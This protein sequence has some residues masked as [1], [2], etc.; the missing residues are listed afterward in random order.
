MFDRVFG[1]VASVVR[2]VGHAAGDAIRKV[3]HGARTAQA[4]LKTADAVFGGVPGEIVRNTPVLSNIAGFA[5]AG[6]KALS[7]F[8]K[9]VEAH[10]QNNPLLGEILRMQHVIKSLG[11]HTTQR[12]QLSTT[13]AA[14]DVRH[15]STISV[16]LPTSGFCDLHTLCMF[17]KGTTTTTAGFAAFPPFTSSLVK[18]LEVLVGG[19][20]VDNI[21]DYSH[22]FWTL[23]TTHGGANY[24]Q[25]QKPAGWADNAVTAPTA[26]T[27]DKPGCID[28]FIGFLSGNPRIV[29]MSLMPPMEVRLTLMDAGVLIPSAA[30]AGL[31]FTLKDIHWSIEVYRF[32]EDVIGQVLSSRL[33]QGGTI[34]YTWNTWT[35]TKQS[36]GT[37]N[38]YSMKASL[39]SMSASKLLAVQAPTATDT[40]N[41]VGNTMFSHTSDTLTSYQ[42]DVNGNY[43]TPA[44]S[45]G[46][47]EAWVNL[48]STF[49][50]QGNIGAPVGVDVTEAS[51][52]ADFFVMA[53]HLNMPSAG[54]GWQS[55]LDLR[56]TASV[57]T[58]RVSKTG[59]TDLVLYIF[60]ESESRMDIGAGRQAVVQL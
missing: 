50:D 53:A 3:G 12:V 34:P 11:Q 60:A 6:L 59:G 57:V 33:A 37:S 10:R 56:G 36:L 9:R 47:T 24:A 58:L 8:D 31:A 40:E 35:S 30:G 45:M 46:P 43:Q 48:L 19:Q 2:K 23:L 7:S 15:G 1:K 41:E 5:D 27:T 18:R 17:F 20:Q 55:G 4:L 21:N 32:Q 49:G 13:S 52:P 26:N 28:H 38:A 29:D 25:S 51:W 54:E 44:Y 42:F 16:R 39:S 22:L 14:T